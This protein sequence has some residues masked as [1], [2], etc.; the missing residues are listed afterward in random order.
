MS[1]NKYHEYRFLFL[2][3]KQKRRKKSYYVKFSRALHGL[4]TSY[5]V[6]LKLFDF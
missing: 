4:P 3:K 6:K 2:D 5:N 1:F